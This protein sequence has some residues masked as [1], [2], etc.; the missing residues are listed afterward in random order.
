MQAGAAFRIRSASGAALISKAGQG[1][2]DPRGGYRG[3]FLKG[4]TTGGWHDKKAR[5]LLCDGVGL[6]AAGHS[7]GDLQN[8]HADGRP[9]QLIS[10]QGSPEPPPIGDAAADERPGKPGAPPIGG[11][12]PALWK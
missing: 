6:T 5:Q 1:R 8:M 2:A 3:A 9:L 4:R 7:S 10:D 12:L 11:R